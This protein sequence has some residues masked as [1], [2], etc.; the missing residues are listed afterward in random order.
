MNPMVVVSSNSKLEFHLVEFF[1]QLKWCT[2]VYRSFWGVWFGLRLKIQ[3]TNVILAHL[4]KGQIYL[5]KGKSKEFK[6]KTIV[7]FFF[8]QTLF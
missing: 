8:L 6:E 1:K 2:I 3:P 5:K 7:P 4:K